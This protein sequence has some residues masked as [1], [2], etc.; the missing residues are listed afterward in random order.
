MLAYLTDAE[1]RWD[2]LESFARAN[3]AVQLVGDRLELAEGATFVFGG[4][5]IDRGPAARRM[6]AT[7]LEARRRYGERVVLLAGNRDIN[8]LRLRAELGGRPPPRAPSEVRGRRAALLQWILANTM[9]ARQAFEHARTEHRA[10]GSDGSDEAVAAR[11]VEDLRP[12]GPLTTYLGHC[13]L[14]YRHGS[15]LFVHGAVTRESLGHI[16]GRPRQD[17]VDGWIA[18]LNRFYAEGLDAYRT[19]PA[20]GETPDAAQAVI[21]YQAPVRGTRANQ[22]SVV[23]GRT[24][25]ADNDPRLPEDEVIAS[26]LAAGLQRLVVGHTPSGDLPSVLR[27]GGFTLVMADNSYGRIERGSRVLIDGER[28]HVRGAC[29]L[30]D[31]REVEVS[32]WADEDPVGLCT[33][34]T[35]HLIKAP[36]PAATAAEGDG[37]MM[38]SRWLLFRALPELKVE[39]VAEAVEGRQRRAPESL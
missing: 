13:Q 37:Q 17:S 34:D 6:V 3:P 30:D 33:A 8:K 11:M 35:G 22:A 18:Q 12:D 19:T 29:Q 5:A 1:G 36:L 23:Y 25:N 4:D 10:D 38:P 2:K 9:G 32:F 7:L 26:L 24:A 16:P 39:Q 14:A 31:G 27:R 21:D 28:V 20:D 15:T